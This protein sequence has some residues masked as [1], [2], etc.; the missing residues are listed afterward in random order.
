M[1]CQEEKNNIIKAAES[2]IK[3]CDESI[4]IWNHLITNS[5]V[6][7]DDGECH[8]SNQQKQKELLVKL[9]ED[10]KKL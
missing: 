9:I 5:M 2:M 4:S 8:I 1:M 3:K 7:K 6:S 10:T